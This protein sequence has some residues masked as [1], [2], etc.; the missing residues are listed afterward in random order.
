MGFKL[1]R[2]QHH[3]IVGKELGPEW[4]PQNAVS[5]EELLNRVILAKALIVLCSGSTV[6]LRT[7]SDDMEI[8]PKI[9]RQL[10]QLAKTTKAKSKSNQR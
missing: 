1:R 9:A 6:H 7:E 4:N 3:R 8:T 5:E 10:I 2:L